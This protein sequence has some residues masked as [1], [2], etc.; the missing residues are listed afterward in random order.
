[1]HVRQILSGLL[2]AIV[3][4]L[5]AEAGEPDAAPDFSA[6]AKSGALKWIWH[7]EPGESATTEAPQGKV[8]LRRSF[9]IPAGKVP[10]RAEFIVGVDNSAEVFVNGQRLGSFR[11]WKPPAR[12][13]IAHLLQAGRNV[14]AVEADNAAA[15]PAGFLGMLELPGSAPVLFD[16]STRSAAAVEG[17]SDWMNPAF[18]DAAWAAATALTPADWGPWGRVS[19]PVENPTKQA[20]PDNFPVFSVP[21]FEKEMDRM[22]QI[23]F[24]HYRLDLSNLPAFNIQ[25]V[26]PAAIWAALDGNPSES[27][28]RASL[29]ARLS[30]MRV[31]KDGYV[32]CHQHEGLGHSEGW[33]FPMYTQSGG[34]GWMFSTAGLPYGAD[35]N[36]HPT[37]GLTGWSF[38]NA[39][40]LGLEKQAGLKL[41]LTGP[42]AAITSPAIKVDAPVASWIRIKLIPGQGPLKPFV[43]WT[44]EDHPDFSD[45]RKV[46]FEL[47][48]G[49][50]PGRP[51]D[52]DVPI[53][54]VTRGEGSI[55]RLRIGFGNTG[56]DEITILR[57]FTSVD[58]RHN[59]NNANFVLAAATYFNWTGD[60][61]FLR[62]FIGT[63]RNIF[64][65]SMEEFAIREHGVIFTPWSGKDGRP[66]MTLDA[67]GKK[68]I[69][70]GQGSGTNY[71]DLMP[72]GG[73]DGYS[74]IYQFAA[75]RAMEQL[76]AAIAAHPEWSIPAPQPEYSAERLSADLGLMRKAYGR[77]FWNP[78]KGRF[79][80]AVDSTGKAWDYG[81]TF[82]NNE[83]MYYGLTTPEQDRQIVDWISGAREIEGETSTGAD[84]YRFRFGP[85]STTVRN[86]DYYTFVWPNPEQIPFGQQVQDGG[87]VFG[88][89]FHDLMGRLRTN[90]PD[91]A[92]ERLKEILAWFGEVQDAGGYRKYY[93][94]DKAAERGTLQGGGP[95]GG[96][97]IDE[98]FHETLLV[99]LIMTEGFLGLTVLPDRIRFAP[100]LPKAWPSLE[101]GG[102][103]YRDWILRAKAT[104]DSLEL[105]LEASPKARPIKV[106]LGPGRWAV[107]ILGGEGQVLSEQAVGEGEAETV[108]IDDP[109]SKRLV[110]T[111]VMP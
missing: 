34:A 93:T 66:G 17:V 35:F 10:D 108:S 75:V 21:G 11:G 82:V 61:D 105:G 71:W 9:E 14:I 95:P 94:A 83:A 24:G 74:T 18:D 30:S 96:L 37:T 91:N 8:W 19:G 80:G 47:P 98:E 64:R 110:A 6:M 57:L 4:T 99:P 2:S 92:W 5:V 81:F 72:F 40:V 49:A 77:T 70:R 12:K 87:S 26:A 60:V 15:S 84:I 38:R 3:L 104:D 50:V 53:H 97:G 68:V 101:V 76:E 33:P 55:T 100:Q 111:R 48:A 44:T 51:V 103:Q 42:D 25:W 29:R 43:Q 39:K 89:S 56:Q 36:V 106:E 31:M 45:D 54:R 67:E 65:Y 62:E 85:R 16:T 7:K 27:H 59:W 13:D 58:T 73:K 102:I 109:A 79:V 90:G 107:K 22:R 28:T 88:F 86:I 69:R 78:D 1:M 63:L 23:L 20:V 32:S 46:A 41:D 52:V